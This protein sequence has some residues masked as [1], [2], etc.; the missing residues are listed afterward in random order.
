MEYSSQ[1]IYILVNLQVLGPPLKGEQGYDP[2]KEDNAGSFFMKPFRMC[3]LNVM[4]DVAHEDYF[5]VE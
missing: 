3:L 5:T 4:D 2:K 1:F